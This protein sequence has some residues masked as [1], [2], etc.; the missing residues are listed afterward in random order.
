MAQWDA[1]WSKFCFKLKSHTHP[2]KELKEAEDI[3]RIG[4]GD[5]VLAA[6]QCCHFSLTQKQVGQADYTFLNHPVRD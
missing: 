6:L 3:V 4:C 2:K 5:P 1:N